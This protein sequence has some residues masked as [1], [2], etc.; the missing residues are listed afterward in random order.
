MMKFD[1][2]HQHYASWIFAIKRHEFGTRF[3]SIK[4]Q[5]SALTLAFVVKTSTIPLKSIAQI[6]ENLFP[7]TNNW[8]STAGFP[9]SNNII[10]KRRV[11]LR[12][13]SQ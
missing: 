13:T 11:E 12:E 8:A 1:I 4:S 7:L 6:E 9:T 2:I 10:I 5:M 3:L